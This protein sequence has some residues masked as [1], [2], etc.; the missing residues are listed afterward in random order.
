MPYYTVYSAP[1]KPPRVFVDG[2]VVG[3]PNPTE[4][5]E[6]VAAYDRAGYQKRSVAFAE[7]DDWQRFMDG[8][9]AREDQANLRLIDLQNRVMQLEAD[10]RVILTNTTP[11][12]A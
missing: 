9:F 1:G 2:A 7:A 5:A 10:H 11:P 3:F 4:L 12:P 6:Y 8:H